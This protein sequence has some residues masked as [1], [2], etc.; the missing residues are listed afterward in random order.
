MPGHGRGAGSSRLAERPPLA[1]RRGAGRRI[2]PALLAVGLWTMVAACP[3]GDG[4]RGE[5]DAAVCLRGEP[6]AA[7]GR[8]PL[9]VA[10]AGDARE[11]S[12][13]RRETH[14]GCERF[15]ID[16]GAG[17]DRP[18]ASA[19][20]VRAEVLRDLGLV[21]VS[22]PNVERVDPDATDANFGGPLARAAYAVRSGEERRLHVDLHLAD[23]AEAYVTLLD[24]PAR[25]VVDLRPGGGAIPEPPVAN[26]RVVVLAPRPGSATYPLTVTGYARTFE[27]NVV[28]RIERN[29][30]EL[31]ETFTTATAWVDAWGRF[32]LP[33]K[34]GPAGP[35]ELHVGE[36]SAR[37]GTW[38][39]VTVE[40][41]ME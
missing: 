12:G 8:L 14:E 20:D 3:G 27:A 7:N 15:V 32:S 40:L 36:Y 24:R 1:P 21:R 41:N 23:E 39:G 35:I 6:F 18:A 31:G 30:E 29:G 25:V 33:I 2:L 28:G 13:L 9:E 11:V 17:D 16:L 34:D 37:D 4:D 26:R 38:E 10:G 19:G 22:L 5:D